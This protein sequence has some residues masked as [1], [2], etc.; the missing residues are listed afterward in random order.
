MEEQEISLIDLAYTL[1]AKWPVLV[2]SFIA[3]AVLTFSVTMAFITPKYE[4]VGKLYVSSQNTRQ[5]SSEEAIA[6]NTLLTSQ[7]LVSTYMEILQSDSFL[8]TVSDDIGGKYTYNQIKSMLSLSALNQTEIMQ[9]SVRCKNP[10]DAYRIAASVIQNSLGEI[11]RVVDG[12][13]V[14]VIDNAFVPSSPVSPDIKKNTLI[15]GLAGI[16]ISAAVIFLMSILDTRVKPGD[17]MQ[18]RY[19]VPV[20]GEIPWIL[21]SK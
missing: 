12:G 1:L 4:S 9:V 2:I 6:Y 19:S 7:R 21:E 18:A 3:A 5:S 13:S 15:G 17:D 10:Y 16:V 14:R 11:E 20:L 8:Q